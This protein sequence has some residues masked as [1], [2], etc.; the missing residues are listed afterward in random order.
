MTPGDVDR[1]DSTEGRRSSDPRF[2]S[3]PRR[4]A[5]RPNEQPAWDLAFLVLGVM[6]ILIDL[7]ISRSGSSRPDV[8]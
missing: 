6:L 5:P 4:P 3:G 2:S 1:A 8:R 7:R